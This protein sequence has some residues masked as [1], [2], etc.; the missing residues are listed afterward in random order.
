MII[1]QMANRKIHIFPGFH[2]YIVINIIGFA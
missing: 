1:L 2:I